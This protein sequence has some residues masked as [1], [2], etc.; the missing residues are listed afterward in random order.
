MTSNDPRGARHSG[1]PTF[2]DPNSSLGP[3][4]FHLSALPIEP[5]VGRGLERTGVHGTPR[6]RVWALESDTLG[7]EPIS[8]PHQLCGLE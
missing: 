1:F 3:T 5:P 6:W 7:F 2:L 4:F 8:A